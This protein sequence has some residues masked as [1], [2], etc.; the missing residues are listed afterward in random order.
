MAMSAQRKELLST[1]VGSNDDFEFYPTT[2]SLI[3]VINQDMAKMNSENEY[4]DIAQKLNITR[5]LVCEIIYRRMK[6]FGFIAKNKNKSDGVVDITDS[7]GDSIGMASEGDCDMRSL[8]DSVMLAGANVKLLD[9]HD[10]W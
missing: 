10:A 2:S 4:F 3:K 5:S 7:Y 6:S 8:L 9:R 1:L